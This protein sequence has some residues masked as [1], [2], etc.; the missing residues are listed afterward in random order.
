MFFIIESN[1]LLIKEQL[2]DSYDLGQQQQQEIESAI[3]RKL[4]KNELGMNSYVPSDDTEP[5]Y[6]DTRTKRGRRKITLQYYKNNLSKS[7]RKFY[8]VFG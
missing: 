3:L 2:Y 4:L 8:W 1:F 7:N 5:R 6:E